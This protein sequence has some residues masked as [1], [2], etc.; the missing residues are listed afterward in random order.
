MRVQHSSIIH[1]WFL[2]TKYL[3]TQLI[4]PSAFFFHT[5]LQGHRVCLQ[6]ASLALRSLAQCWLHTGD[7]KKVKESAP[8]RS[9]Y[10]VGSTRTEE[11]LKALVRGDTIVGVPCRRREEGMMKWKSGMKGVA[12]PSDSF[13][14]LKEQLLALKG[15]LKGHGLFKTQSSMVCVWI[16]CLTLPC[17][18]GLQT[19][20]MQS[21]RLCELLACA[22]S[23]VQHGAPT[24]CSE[25]CLH[26]Y[27]VSW[28]RLKR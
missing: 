20:R 14:L 22:I 2:I 7:V 9:M 5:V 16:Y 8:P 3:D 15:L 28:W 25:R 4:W 19:S 18:S 26:C 11:A 23:R 13:H 17:T 6:S 12:G 24:S 1:Y 21:G 27:T 10:Q